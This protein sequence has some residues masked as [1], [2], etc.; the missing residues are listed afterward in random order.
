MWESHVFWKRK[1][2]SRST[3]LLR[4]FWSFPPSAFNI[5]WF[6]QRE[7]VVSNCPHIWQKSTFFWSHSLHICPGCLQFQHISWEVFGPSLLLSS[8]FR[9]RSLSLRG[10]LR[11]MAKTCS[12]SLSSSSDRSPTSR[13]WTD[14]LDWPSLDRDWALRHQI[15]NTTEQG[16]QLSVQAQEQVAFYIPVVAT[17]WHEV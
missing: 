1:L 14:D 5:C 13:W 4:V 12:K 8:R 15:W 10:N 16:V 2:D 3:P 6:G 11:L 7:A 9:L 17:A